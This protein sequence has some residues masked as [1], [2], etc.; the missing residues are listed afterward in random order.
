MN[1]SLILG[2]STLALLTASPALAQ[3]T[4]SPA[5]GPTVEALLRLLVQDGV[6]S[7]AKADALYAAAA[8]EPVSPAPPPTTIAAAPPVATQ[9]PALT[10]ASA[11]PAARA[12]IGLE[13]D[14]SGGAPEFS[15]DGFRFKPRGR[16]L[17]DLSTTTD[18]DFD[19]RNLTAT[20]ARAIR[21]GFEGGVGNNLF[22]QV[23][24]DF[25]ESVVGVTS[26]Y[27]GWRDRL[28]G[29]PVEISLGQ[30]LSERGIE[31]STGSD[32]T[33]F[34]ERNVIGTALVPQKG[35]FGL[36]VIGKVYGDNWH[37]TAQ[38]AGD[39][40]DDDAASRDTLTFMQRGHWNPVKTDTTILHLGAWG[41]QEQFP[42]NAPIIS[43][44]T[45]IGGRFNDMLRLSSGPLGAPDKGSGYG[46]ELGG[47]WRSVWAFAEGGFRT[48][49]YRDGVASTRFDAL[50]LSAG[51]FVTGDK[52]GYS[53]RIG[54]WSQPKVIRSVFDGG[55]G[56]VELL[57]RWESLDYSDAPFG[58][59]GQATTLGANW[60]LNDFTRLMLNAI[61]W[62]IDNAS[63]AYVGQDEGITI[64]ARAQVSF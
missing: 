42:A 51:W 57:T 1:R 60:Y 43:R 26:A 30:R 27:V 13:V 35:F 61:F 53:S 47:V 11:S 18:S 56:A 33:P 10:A 40:L 19:A 8:A 9:A 2:V 16:I 50:S 44:N 46:L 58:G 36:G 63:G 34:L 41:F 5:Q 49:D 55:S 7:Q 59:E 39:D 37:L 31:G 48:L 22:Y 12:D 62:D 23:E 4:A 3:N 21:L 20:G 32:A 28:F 29:R 52:P 54:A 14:W 6:V 45:A 17:A 24:A 25:S 64:T 15:G 38:I